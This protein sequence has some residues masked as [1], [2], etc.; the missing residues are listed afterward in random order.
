MRKGRSRG[1]VSWNHG[2]RIVRSNRRRDKTHGLH[3]RFERY[4]RYI[5]PM[6]RVATRIRVRVTGGMDRSVT[7]IIS[8]LRTSERPN[9]WRVTLRWNTS[10]RCLP[11][12]TD[13]RVSE[14]VSVRKKRV[15]TRAMNFRL[16]QESFPIVQS[17]ISATHHEVHHLAYL[18]IESD[19]Q[20][21]SSD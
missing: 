9:P 12:Q 10:N 14:K 8:V 15:R 7:A 1:D 5:L 6:G 17:R 2:R 18:R 4:N 16:C 21:T 19:F 20:E 13:M 11:I 3:Q